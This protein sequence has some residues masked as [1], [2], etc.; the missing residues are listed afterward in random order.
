ML[1]SDDHQKRPLGRSC[2]V[3]SAPGSDAMDSL[4][5]TRRFWLDGFNHRDEAVVR[6]AIAEGY[7]NDA[8]LPGTPEGPEGQVAVLRRIWTAFPD[9]HFEIEHLARDGDHVICIGTMSGTHSGAFF[10]VDASD[11]R[12]A[13]RQCHIVTTDSAGRAIRHRAIRDDLGLIEQMRGD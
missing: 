3:S 4:E 11:R 1:S 7:V 9:A 12:I 5:R 2:W 6:D 8:A 10:G 13:W